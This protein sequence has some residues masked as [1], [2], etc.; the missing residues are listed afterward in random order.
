ML[1]CSRRVWADASS[2]V[3]GAVT[4]LLEDVIAQH[5]L[6]R[7]SGHCRAY[8]GNADGEKPPPSPPP[9]WLSLLPPRAAGY[10]R[11]WRRQER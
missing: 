6:T 11:W 10:V 1:H 7:D 8:S 2:V 3:R 4:L 9:P 5:H